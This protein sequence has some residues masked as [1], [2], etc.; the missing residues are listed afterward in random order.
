[1]QRKDAQLRLVVDRLFGRSYEATAAALFSASCRSS[2]DSRTND[3][4]FT[5]WRGQDRTSA[6]FI[7]SLSASKRELESALESIRAHHGPNTTTPRIFRSIRR[8][9]LREKRTHA[10]EI[11]NRR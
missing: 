6:V 5:V 7:D 4:R 2:A 3:V 11:L 10:H 8:V 1:M 9:A